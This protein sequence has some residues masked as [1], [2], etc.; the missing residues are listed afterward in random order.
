[1]AIEPRFEV[2]PERGRTYD[3][4]GALI[5]GA[6]ELTGQFV[7][8]FQDAN[9]RITFTGGE[10]FTRREDAHRSIREAVSAIVGADV[11]TVERL[12][13]IPIVD[14]DA[15]GERIGAE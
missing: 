6:Y 5:E 12:D 1:M 8:H 10:P 9:G 7:W 4:S 14:L 13:L 3:E 15:D 2:F 11:A